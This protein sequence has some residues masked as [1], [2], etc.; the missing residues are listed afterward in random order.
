M[1][2]YLRKYGHITDLLLLIIQVRGQAHKHVGHI[3]GIAHTRWATHGGKTDQNAHPH[4]DQHNRIAL[5]HNGTINNSYELKKM[6]QEKHGIKF[7]SETDTEGPNVYY[8]LCADSCASHSGY[9]L[10]VIAQLIGIYLDKG[11]STQDA[12]SKALSL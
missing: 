12:L 4:T 3:T 10:T 5:I 2:I 1:P 6:L 9:I 7:L 11:L 8:Y